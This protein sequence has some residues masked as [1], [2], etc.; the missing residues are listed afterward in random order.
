MDVGTKGGGHTQNLEDYTYLV[1]NV[2]CFL[3]VPIVKGR[4]LQLLIG[5]CEY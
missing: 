1:L 3:G 2:D 4:F 5:L